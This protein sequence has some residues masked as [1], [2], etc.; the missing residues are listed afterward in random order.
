M[1]QPTGSPV[2]ILSKIPAAIPGGSD[3]PVVFQIESAGGTVAASTSDAVIR[4]F[5]KQTLGDK[6]L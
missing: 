3:S 5:D 4:L 2:E 6:G 1:S